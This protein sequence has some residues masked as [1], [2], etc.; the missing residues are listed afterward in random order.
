MKII[1]THVLDE[2]ALQVAEK[3]L[4][5]EEAKRRHLVI[6]LSGAHA[7][8]F[9]S[10]DSD[11]DLKAVHAE[12]TAHLLGL[13]SPQN[14][15]D[16]LEFVEGVEIDYTS[17]EIRGVLAGILA[18]NGN[19]IE[20]I[21]G[22]HILHSSPEHE[23]LKGIVHEELKGIVPGLLSK[24]V[25][26]HYRGFASSQRKSF[27]EAEAPTAKKL[28]YVLRTALTGAHLLRT[29]ELR[30]DLRTVASE[31]GFEEAKALIEAKRAGEKAVLSQGDRD[32]WATRL[33]AL[34]ETL[35]EALAASPLPAE[36]EGVS[37]LQDWLVAMRARE[38]QG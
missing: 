25:H 7:Y 38:L 15:F 33:D 26:R 9:P 12:K 6:A 22:A 18:G 29:G 30:V 4:T 3:V 21:L 13:E 14:S 17:N 35:E 10:P 24:R 5:A 16:R 27:E 20:R 31:Y 2:K 28:L 32:Y 11:L 19:Y 34:F 1:D 23:E 36:P 37:E 8:G